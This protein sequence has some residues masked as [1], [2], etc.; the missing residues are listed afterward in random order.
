L[1]PEPS[2][3][4]RL[5]LPFTGIVTFLRAPVCTDLAQLDADV[6]I[7]GIPTDEGTPW[8]PGSRMAPRAIREM[9]VRF[10]SFGAD[11]YGWYDRDE[12]RRY[13]DYESAH[14]RIIDCGDVDVIFT[15]VEQTFRNATSDVQAI[16][17]AGAMPVLIGGD[18]AI[19]YPV[20]RA[21]SEPLDVVHFDAHM[22]YLPFLHGVAFSNSH[23]IRLISEL[24]HVGRIIQ[25]GIRSLRNHQSDISD[26]LARGNDVVT[27]KQLRQRGMQAVLDELGEGRKVYVSIDID[28]LD[29]PLVPGCQSAEV[30]G[31]SYDELKDALAHIAKH[32]EIVGFDLVEV[33]PLL[34]V[35]S[36]NTSLLAAQLILE[37]LGRIVDNPA[38]QARHRRGS[39]PLTT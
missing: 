22:D 18:H 26:S 38:W 11:G 7:L 12:D 24:P 29:M 9:S 4:T 6:A 19:A 32:H 23:P 25:V 34:D 2:S 17:E 36:G 15:N 30:G 21:Y 37:F 3:T 5:N 1:P 8:L 10:A 20:V 13:L 35:A 31:L 28:V 39:A 16:L 14:Q 33:N 27:V